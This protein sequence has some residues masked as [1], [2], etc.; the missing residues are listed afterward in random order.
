MWSEETSYLKYPVC[1][2]IEQSS[3]TGPE[4]F[5]ERSAAGVRKEQRKPGEFERRRKI[6]RLVGN[7]CLW[8]RVP[9]VL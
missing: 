3:S 9:A 2:A 1:T 8:I 4:G 7:L 6:S 5:S